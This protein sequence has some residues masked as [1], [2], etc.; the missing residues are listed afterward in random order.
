MR[1]N[2]NGTLSLWGKVE[3]TG[4]FLLVM[5]WLNYCDDQNLLPLVVCA[6]A[7]HELGHLA[8]ITAVGGR[9]CCLRLTAAGAEIRMAGVPGYGRELLCALAGPL[10]SLL[11][12]VGAARIGALV[13]AGMNLALGVF[14]LLP[15]RMLDGGRALSCLTALL[16]GPQWAFCL[17]RGVDVVLAAALFLCGVPAFLHGG[18][19]TLPVISLCIMAAAGKQK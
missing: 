19:I 1:L 10:V 6:A 4:G 16:F 15:L 5:A 2:R 18:N 14:N 12:A 9:V 8:A 11:L 13:F 7:A 3:I 17:G